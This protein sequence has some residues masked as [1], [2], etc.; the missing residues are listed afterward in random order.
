MADAEQGRPLGSLGVLKGAKKSIAILRIEGRGGLIGEDQAR[1]AQERAGHCH[2]LLLPHGERPHGA[3]PKGLQGKAEGAK[4]FFRGDLRG[5]PGPGEAR[6]TLRRE[7]QWQENVI[8][9]R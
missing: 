3:T 5:L 2:P 6:P 4:K 1:A 7:T 8:E 9:D